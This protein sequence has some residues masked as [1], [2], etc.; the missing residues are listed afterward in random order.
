M[1]NVLKLLETVTGLL[2]CCM[3]IVVFFMNNSSL[4]AMLLSAKENLNNYSVLYEQYQNQEDQEE[5]VIEYED[6]ISMLMKDIS[7]DMEINMVELNADTYDYLQFDFSCIPNTA[8]KRSYQ[9]DAAGTITKVIYK[10][11]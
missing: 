11:I 3:A 7:T 4:N 1:E 5:P 2:F 9:R 10:S 6:L 8:Y